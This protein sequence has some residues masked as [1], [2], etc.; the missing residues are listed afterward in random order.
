MKKVVNIALLSMIIIEIWVED[1]VTKQVEQLTK[2][3]QQ[4]Q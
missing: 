1:Q 2:V 4:L 3:I